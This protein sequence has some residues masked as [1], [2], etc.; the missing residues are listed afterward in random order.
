MAGGSGIPELKGYLNGTNVHRS[1]TLLGRPVY[2]LRG[3][4]AR[5]SVCLSIGSIVGVF[6]E[7]FVNHELTNG[8][9][10]FIRLFDWLWH[11]KWFGVC[12]CPHAA[13]QHA[14]AHTNVVRRLLRLKTL[15]VKCVGVLFSVSGGL[16]IG[17]AGNN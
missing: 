5:Q 17:K 12:P 6:S 14:H 3:W 8:C 1:A 13:R 11:S 15:F 10:F 16:C 9:F 7:S 2:W 4:L